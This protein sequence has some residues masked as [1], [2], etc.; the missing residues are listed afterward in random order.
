MVR[1]FSKNFKNVKCRFFMDEIARQ[2][3]RLKQK[4]APFPEKRQSKELPQ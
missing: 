1:D 3:T 4:Q 2:A